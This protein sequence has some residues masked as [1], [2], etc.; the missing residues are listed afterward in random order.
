MRISDT[1][2]AADVDDL[3]GRES[4]LFGGK[5]GRRRSDFVGLAD[6]PDR[7]AVAPRHDAAHPLG[8]GCKHRRIDWPGAMTLT[9]TPALANSNA[10]D[11]A[12][13]CDAHLAVHMWPI[14]GT[15][16]SPE[17]AVMKIIRPHLRGTIER[18]AACETLNMPF[19]STANTSS[20][21]FS[22]ISRNGVK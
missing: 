14:W 16:M 2:A 19:T 1:E 15:P 21:S 6:S 17:T 3:A 7:R 20:H 12:R 22:V 11:A 5:V 9:V 18:S 8:R 10:S 13:P 4:R